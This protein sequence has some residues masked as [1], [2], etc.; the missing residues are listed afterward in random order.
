MGVSN[1]RWAAQVLCF[2]SAARRQVTVAVDR[3]LSARFSTQDVSGMRKKTA[4]TAMGEGN[5]RRYPSCPSEGGV[6][7][8]SCATPF[9]VG[10]H[11]VL[12]PSPRG[13]REKAFEPEIPSSVI[14]ALSL[15]RGRWLPSASR[16]LLRTKVRRRH[17]QSPTV[18]KRRA[19]PWEVGWRERRLDRG[20]LCR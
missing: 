11:P 19:T 17:K 10:S 16:V 9:T 6:N 15:C 18:R 14:L 1:P 12:N 13:R 4:G 2:G 7:V 8:H 5:E 3:E 20:W